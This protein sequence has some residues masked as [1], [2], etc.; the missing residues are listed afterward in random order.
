M[1]ICAGGAAAGRRP[2]LR[3]AALEA[4]RAESKVGEPAPGARPVPLSLLLAAA[5]ASGSP[6]A[7]PSASSVNGAICSSSPPSSLSSAAAAPQQLQKL[8]TQRS[9][10]LVTASAKC[11][12]PH[13]RGVA[14]GRLCGMV[15]AQAI[16]RRRHPHQRPRLAPGA[17]CAAVPRGLAAG[18]RGGR[19]RGPHREAARGRAEPRA[20]R[21]Q[22]DAR[23]RG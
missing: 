4:G 21:R 17:A 18:P 3:S 6:A 12:A 10:L 13:G 5:S 7:A 19:C 2:R 8:L 14:R 11:A 20:G 23:R 1:H 16:P 22:C 15:A 9:I